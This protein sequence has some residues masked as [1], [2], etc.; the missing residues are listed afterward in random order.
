MNET[1][2]KNGVIINCGGMKVELVRR[3]PYRGQLSIEGRDVTDPTDYWNYCEECATI[4]A[5][6]KGVEPSRPDAVFLDELN[7]KID[8]NEDLHELTKLG[9]FTGRTVGRV[10]RF[11]N[12]YSEFVFDESVLAQM[13]DYDEFLAA[14]HY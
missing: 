12:I 8:L 2:E 9:F 10:D 11:I 6:V 3:E 7:L 4:S 14:E 13:R 5:Y 1:G